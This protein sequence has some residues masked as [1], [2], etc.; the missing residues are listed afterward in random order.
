ML[1]ATEK[2]LGG[3]MHSG[4]KKEKLQ[5]SLN[6][7]EQYQILLILS[8][9]KSKETIIIEPFKNNDT[10]YWRDSDDIHHVPKR[11]LEEI[12]IRDPLLI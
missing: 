5:A 9:G 10:K 6:I 11:T 3:C 8:L 1:G 2:G 4:F 12:L 7:S